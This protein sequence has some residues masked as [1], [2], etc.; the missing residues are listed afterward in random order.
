MIA[1][2]Q[3]HTEPVS[4][5]KELQDLEQGKPEDGGDESDV[6]PDSLNPRM[7]ALLEYLQAR[8][9]VTSS[10]QK[11][12]N[13]LMLSFSCAVHCI[14]T[15][16]LSLSFSNFRTPITTGLRFRCA[17]RTGMWSSLSLGRRPQPHLHLWE[18]LSCLWLLYGMSRLGKNIRVEEDLISYLFNAH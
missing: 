1:L 2:R 5:M 6:D 9:Q 14:H 11:K 15:Y 18:A 13:V 17:L 16:S 8:W 4:L 7:Q 12:L 3:K 10:Q